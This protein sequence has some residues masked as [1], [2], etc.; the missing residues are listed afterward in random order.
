MTLVFRLMKKLV[1]GMK[2]DVRFT[3]IRTPLQMC[4]RA[5]ELANNLESVLFPIAERSDDTEVEHTD[6]M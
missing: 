6:I 2:F 3:F 5:V 4:H 1:D